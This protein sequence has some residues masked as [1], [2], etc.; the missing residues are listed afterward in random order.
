MLLRSFAAAVSLAGSDLSESGKTGSETPVA[1]YS[2]V[3]SNEGCT[4]P[5]AREG[6][7]KT[8]GLR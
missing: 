4:T 8:S 3:D 5:P 1:R 2:A 7:G 6:M